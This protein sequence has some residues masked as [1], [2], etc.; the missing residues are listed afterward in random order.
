MVSGT[1]EEM[2]H[3]VRINPTQRADVAGILINAMLKVS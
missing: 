2:G 3:G 1:V